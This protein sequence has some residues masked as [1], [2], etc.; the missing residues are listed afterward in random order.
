MTKRQEFIKK[1]VSEWRDGDKLLW[2]DK[3]PTVNEVL[4]FIDDS[5]EIGS[6]TDQMQSTGH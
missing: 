1:Y 2:K 4:E 6:W 5:E 3:C